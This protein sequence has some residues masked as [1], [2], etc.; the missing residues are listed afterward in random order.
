MTKREL[1]KRISDTS[2]LPQG[3]SENALNALGRIIA[4]EL[5]AGGSIP[6]PGVGTI[7]AQDPDGGRRRTPRLKPSKRLKESLNNS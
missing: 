5:C 1:I 3:Y 4:E 7:G 6:L 2:G